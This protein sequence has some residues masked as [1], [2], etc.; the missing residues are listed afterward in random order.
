MYHGHN[1]TVVYDK[2]GS[3]YKLGKGITVFV[4]GKKSSLVQKENKYA[5]VIPTSI[6]KHST[7]EDNDYALNIITQWLS[8]SVCFCKYKS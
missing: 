4:D 1:V 6:V 3:K 8:R 5:V 7:P 2:D